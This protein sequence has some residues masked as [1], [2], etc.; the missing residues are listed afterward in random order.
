M[1]IQWIHDEHGRGIELENIYYSYFGSPKSLDGF[2]VNIFDMTSQYFW[3]SDSITNVELT[4]DDDLRLIKTMIT[5][6]KKVK[7]LIMLPNNLVMTHGYMRTELKNMLEEFKINLGKLVMCPFS[8]IGFE[9]TDNKVINK[10][11][12]AD[13]YFLNGDKVHTKSLYSE[14]ETTVSNL[15]KTI[16]FTSLDINGFDLNE[17]E[18]YLNKI[19]LTQEQLE[20]EPDWM[21]GIEMFD[22]NEQLEKI[23][24]AEQKINDEKKLISQSNAILE[25]NKRYK[26]I[27]YTQSD[28]L[29]E[30]V[31][32]M[33]EEMLNIDLSGFVDKKKE[34]LLFELNGNIFIV[35]IK[36]LTSNIKMN[37][38]SQLDRH[39]ADYIDEHPDVNT[40]IIYKLLVVNSQRTLPVEER[41]EMHESQ[42]EAATKRYEQLII[43]TP[44][45]LKLY[46]KYRNGDITREE[47]INLFQQTGKLTIE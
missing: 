2:D 1:K 4:V 36:G 15:E 42:L 25:R 20:R 34:D 37:N 11:V 38:L 30:V 3:N 35:E 40:N 45:L 44:E 43:E 9:P 46:E 28:N 13:F 14:K 6:S 31:F 22:D 17:L 24:I 10:D 41:K 5:N 29:V 8:E 33:F 39:Y 7:L 27:L 16:Y 26:S 23:Q 21:G 32:E 18:C 47:I 19:E 12:Q